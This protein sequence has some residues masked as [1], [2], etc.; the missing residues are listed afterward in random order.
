M[1][2]KNKMATKSQNGHQIIKMIITHS[3]FKLEALDFIWQFI[4]TFCKLQILGGKWPPKTKLP[5]NRKINNNSLNF[6]A[7]SS[8]FYMVVRSDPLLIT[9]FKNKMASI[10]C[11]LFVQKSKKNDNKSKNTYYNRRNYNNKGTTYFI[12][13]WPT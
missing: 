4:L 5:P 13:E 3:I 6:Q 8:I 10:L 9:Q 2:I 7:R 1:A 11:Q 12:T